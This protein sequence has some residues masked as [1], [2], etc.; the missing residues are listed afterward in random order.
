MIRFPKK[1]H[2]SLQISTTDIPHSRKKKKKELSPGQK[3]T[4]SRTRCSWSAASYAWLL[5]QPPPPPTTFSTP[6]ASTKETTFSGQKPNQS[7]QED[8]QNHHRA[9]QIDNPRR[10]TG[11]SRSK[12]RKRS[13]LCFPFLR[14]R[15]SSELRFLGG[16]VGQLLRQVKGQRGFSSNHFYV[17]RTIGLVR[18]GPSDGDRTVGIGDF[19][20]AGCLVLRD[21]GPRERNIRV[22]LWVGFFV[23]P[24]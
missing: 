7:V 4:T 18:L 24:I 21:C 17:V 13:N 10:R 12:N 23:R 6:P 5:F 19:G 14:P 2:Q 15:P 20:L 11:G 22:L 16:G 9:A 3:Q 8:T 1:I